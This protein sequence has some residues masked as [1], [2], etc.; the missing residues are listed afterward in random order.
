MVDHMLRGASGLADEADLAGTALVAAAI[1]GLGAL[2]VAL[3]QRLCR[4]RIAAGSRERLA[5]LAHLNRATTATIY[6]GA[7]AHEL[8]QPLAAIMANTEAAELLLACD[9]P[10]VE[11]ARQ[12]LADI[13]RDDRRASDIIGRMRGMLKPSAQVQ[14]VV[15]LR[16]VAGDAIGFIEPEVNMRRASVRCLMPEVPLP[17]RGDPVQLQQVLINL[18]I[19][20]LDAMAGVA[21]HERVVLV[22]AFL[23]QD[24]RHVTLRVADHGPGFT[25]DPAKAFDGFVTTKE[26]GT[27]LGLA[28]SAAIVREHG[29]QIEARNLEP[30][31]AEVSLVLPIVVDAAAD[32]GCC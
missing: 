27:G 23:E 13:R 12:A 15:D 9:P 32:C 1:A 31:G 11:E 18:V 8:N 20:A 26:H 3:F 16:T 25:G 28:I 24:G 19:N 7:I 14:G 30:F 5:Q 17:V 10:Q 21:P 2:V 6:A 29:G 22:L 4:A